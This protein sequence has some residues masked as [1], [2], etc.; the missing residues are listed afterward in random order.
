VVAAAAA[1]LLVDKAPQGTE[2]IKQVL[3]GNILTT[4]TRELMTVVPLYAV[5][6]LILWCARG[7][8][9]RASGGAAGWL[10]DFLFYACFGLVVTSSVALAGVLLVF[11]F[12]I[13]PAAVRM[14]YA[15]GGRQL[16]IGWAVGI[17]ASAAGL[18]ASYAWDLP[19]GSTMV[20]AF[21]AALALAGA[22]RPLRQRNLAA[23]AW[24]TTR[25]ATA[26][27]LLASGTWLA[28]MPRADQPL[29]D[30]IEYF[31]PGVR[32]AYFNA[33]E[34]VIDREAREYAERYRR[35]AERLNEKEAKSRWQGEAVSDYEVRRISS[36]LQSY[37]EMRK[38]EEFVQ[39]EVR[40]RARERQR[41]WLGGIAILAAAALFP[42]RRRRFKP[43]T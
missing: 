27:L 9:S 36:F 23:A 11:S 2:H 35:E 3:T 33:G 14:L 40:A 29:L 34:T 12:L 13:I 10:W 19:T 7:P 42:W 20:C 31:A 41:W 24:R 21:G 32:D 28:A 38:G 18:A 4:G 43:S 17:V 5:A 39:R 37:N 25:L 16:A 26:L 1:F 22:L 8:M 15:E 6:A 30:T